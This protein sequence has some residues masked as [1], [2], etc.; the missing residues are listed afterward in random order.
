MSPAAGARTTA[1]DDDGNGAVDD[2]FPRDQV[3]GDY[4]PVDE[5][6]HGTQVAGTLAAR[7]NDGFGTTGL[8]WR[9]KLMPIRVL[10]R[11]GDGDTAAVAAGFRDAAQR[12]ASIVNASMEGA[13]S[14]AIAD[15]IG[16]F[17]VTLFV[18]AAGNGGREL[19]DGDPEWPCSYTFVEPDLR[20]RGRRRREARVVL[21]L[22]PDLGR[23]RGA[24]RLRARPRA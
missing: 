14:I 18:V 4:D 17:P 19:D 16:D 10:D 15:A 20:R 11:W 8:A 22:R 2:V 12:G 1:L 5:N 7:G 9:A 3:D 24:R 6:G 21:E 13:R 23:P